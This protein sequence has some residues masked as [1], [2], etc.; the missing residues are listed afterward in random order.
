M[1][2][3]DQ[4]RVGVDVYLEW[5]AREGIPV[6]EDFGADLLAVAALESP[7]P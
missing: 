7:A 6:T 4:P 5:L 1:N 3:P 2:A